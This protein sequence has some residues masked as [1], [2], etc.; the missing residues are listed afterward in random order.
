[1]NANERNTLVPKFNLGDLVTVSTHP[2]TQNNADITLKT[3]AE[4]TSPIFSI[5]EI[6]NSNLYK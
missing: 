2:F 3:R 6:K 1:M 5:F 4:Y